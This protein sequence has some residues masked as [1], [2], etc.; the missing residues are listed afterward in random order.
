M[1][2]NVVLHLDIFSFLGWNV[3]H[4]KNQNLFVYFIFIICSKLCFFSKGTG[5]VFWITLYISYSLYIK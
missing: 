2:A 1:A 3:A 4:Y 5:F